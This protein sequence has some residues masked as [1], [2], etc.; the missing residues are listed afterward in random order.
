MVSKMLKN[1]GMQVI[2]A[3]TGHEAIALAPDRADKPDL[4][5][6]DV[7]L[8]DIDG[9][10]VCRRLKSDP[11]T[12]DIKILHTS[13]T[14][15]TSDNRVEGVEAGADG[16]LTQ[17][18]EPQDLIATVRALLRLHEAEANL[19]ARNGQLVEADRRKDEFLA[20]LAHE[21]RN[22]L[23][24]LHMGLPVLD[25]FPPHDELEQQ[26]PRDHAAPAQPSSPGSSTTCS[27]SAR[28]SRPHR[29]APRADGPRR[30]WSRAWSTSCASGSPSRAGRRSASSCPPGRCRC[31]PT[32][33]AS[34]RC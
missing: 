32:A 16:Y 19:V 6:L 1:A 34:S 28:H 11:R 15:V 29:A 22:P 2:E 13:A 26:T 7:R 33:G 18:F 14:F 9:L 24:A 21:L 30:S 3:S 4:V 17:P 20:M 31:P 8:P 25:R 12:K 5:V 23:A 10:E 27:T